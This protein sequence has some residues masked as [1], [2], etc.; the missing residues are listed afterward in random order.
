MWWPQ[1]SHTGQHEPALGGRRPERRGLGVERRAA[2]GELAHRAHA[3]ST[4]VALPWRVDSAPPVPWARA[5]SQPG[6]LHRG[7]GLA[8]ELAHRLDDLGHA[9][10]VGGVVVA[11]PAAV[12]VEGQA[13]AG[14]AQRAVGHER[15]ALALL[16]EARGPR[17]R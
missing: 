14:A 11:Q 4:R 15:A 13:T 12:G 16:A 3:P 9:A 10:A 7:V 8:A 5:S 2:G 1:A 6:H 17:A